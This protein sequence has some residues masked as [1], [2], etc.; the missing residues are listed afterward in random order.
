MVMQALKDLTPTVGL[1]VCFIFHHNTI[2]IISLLM[3][4]HILG[5]LPFANGGGFDHVVIPAGQCE[6]PTTAGAVV[7][8]IVFSHDRYCNTQLGCGTNAAGD[9]QAGGLGTVCSNQ[10]PFKIS[11]LTDGLEYGFPAATSENGAPRNQ[12]FSLSK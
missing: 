2:I 10:K 1:L 9:A 11:V 4:S 6:S 12:G 7:A 3:T 8:D 5:V